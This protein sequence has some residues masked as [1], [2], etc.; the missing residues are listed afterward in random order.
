MSSKSYALVFVILSTTPALA[1]N[2]P[3]KP[4]PL[5]LP[6]AVESMLPADVSGQDVRI[7]DGCY[8]YIYEGEVFQVGADQ[9][10]KIC[11]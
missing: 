3:G 5:P 1:D 9:G 7:V 6:P 8:V 2:L 11:R 10:K 4:A